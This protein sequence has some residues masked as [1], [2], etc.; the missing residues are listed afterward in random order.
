M[1]FNLNEY[2]PVKARK[3]RF[4]ADHPDGRI[5]VSL[6]NSEESIQGMAL[7][8]AAVFL[9]AEDQA[10]GLPRATGYALELRDTELKQTR[11]GKT[12][13]SVNFTSWTENSEE[14]SVGRALDNAGYASNMKASREEMEKVERMSKTVA[15]LEAG[16]KKRGDYDKAVDS[17]NKAEGILMLDTLRAQIDERE[18]D[19]GRRDKLVQMIDAKMAKLSEKLFAEEGK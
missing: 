7:F 15:N 1:K 17:I 9:T 18:W 13:E 5:I 14:S 11:D 3:Q 8:K 12:Y 6:V 2:E 19:N 4:Y 16:L 10:K